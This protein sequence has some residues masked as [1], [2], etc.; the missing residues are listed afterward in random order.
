MHGNDTSTLATPSLST[1]TSYIIAISTKLNGM[2]GSGIWS[3]FAHTSRSSSDSVPSGP[4]SNGPNPSSSTSVF[5][6]LLMVR[7]LGHHVDLAG[8]NEIDVLFVRRT[9]GAPAVD[10]VVPRDRLVEAPLLVRFV[11][12]DREL[13]VDDVLVGLL[14]VVCGA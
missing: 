12:G 10:D 1:S 4:M 2:W 13:V 3:R 7:L 5:E 6:V 11:E 8:L 9:A 14:V